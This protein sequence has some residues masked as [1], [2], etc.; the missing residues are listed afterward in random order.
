M[1]TTSLLH[2]TTL[3]WRPHHYCRLHSMCLHNTTITV[4]TQRSCV[5][6]L[7]PPSM[8]RFALSRHSCHLAACCQAVISFSML[9][10]P[11]QDV[12]CG[13]PY[14]LQG[15]GRGKPYLHPCAAMGTGAA[16][17]LHFRDV[18]GYRVQIPNGSSPIDI[19]TSIRG[20]YIL[21]PSTPLYGFP[22]LL[23]CLA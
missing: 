20:H 6:P 13:D 16:D 22:S 12:G 8:P 18:Y 3:L 15:H 19:P 10:A 17:F 14:Q 1:T 23:S 21:T 4:S 2:D 7:S 11:P 9:L 5:V